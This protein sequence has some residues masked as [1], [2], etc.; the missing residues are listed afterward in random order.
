VSPIY[1]L[2]SVSGDDGELIRLTKKALHT[3]SFTHLDF[4]IKR[5]VAKYLYNEGRGEN[6][7]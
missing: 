7:N 2:V 3:R 1:K 5:E 4:F 6:V